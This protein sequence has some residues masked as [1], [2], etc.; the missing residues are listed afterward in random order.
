[1]SS[2]GIMAS[3][4]ASYRPGLNPIKGLFRPNVCPKH[5]ELILEINKTVIVASSWCSILLYRLNSSL[6]IANISDTNLQLYTFLLNT[7]MGFGADRMKVARETVRIWRE[8]GQGQKCRDRLSRPYEMLI[9][10]D[11]QLRSVCHWVT[12]KNRALI[13]LWRIISLSHQ[14]LT[15]KISELW[16]TISQN[17]PNVWTLR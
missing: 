16:S 5:V 12:V 4:K 10:A 7:F 8:L 3:K 11:D 14:H 13:Y 17:L 6:Q 9:D 1:M 2:Q 15:F